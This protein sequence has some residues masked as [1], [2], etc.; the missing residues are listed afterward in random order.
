ML[1]ETVANG[2]RLNFKESARET[3][4]FIEKVDKF[5]DSLNVTN[6]TDCIT[7]LKQFKMPYRHA[8]DFRIKVMIMQLLILL[9][10]ICMYTFCIVVAKRVSRLVGRV[11]KRDSCT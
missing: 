10:Y 6:Y 4:N 11:G 2:L 3:A 8:K 1:S 9:H 5:F 7:K